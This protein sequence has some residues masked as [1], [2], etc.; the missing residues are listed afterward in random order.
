MKK[1]LETH[2]HPQTSEE[3]IALSKQMKRHIYKNFMKRLIDSDYLSNYFKGIIKT[4]DDYFMF[5]K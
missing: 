5:R 4:P 1:H 3:N 2:E